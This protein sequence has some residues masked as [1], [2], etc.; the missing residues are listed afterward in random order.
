M[1]KDGIHKLY[2]RSEEAEDKIRL[3][4]SRHQRFPQI[5]YHVYFCYLM[6]DPRSILYIILTKCTSVCLYYISDT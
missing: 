3:M 1:Y 6:N 5:Y 4:F 2:L